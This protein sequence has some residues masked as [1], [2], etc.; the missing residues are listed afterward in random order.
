M[1]ILKLE[2]KID[3]VKKYGITTMAKVL[4]E[5]KVLHDYTDYDIKL[6][7]QEY[8]QNL[9]K[10]QYETELERWYYLKTGHNLDL[11]NPKRFT[12]KI[13]WMKLY[14]FGDLETRLVDKYLVR[15]WIKE[16]IGENYL[17]PLIGV[18]ENADEIDFSSLPKS[19]MLKGN[20][21]SQMN[22]RV[23]DK[24]KLNYKK[25]KAT[26]GQWLNLD[27]SHCLG[28]FELQYKNVPRRLLA[29]KL[30]I[31]DGKSDLSDYKFHC[32]DGK[33]KFCE[34][35][36]NR[37]TCETIDYY[38]MDWNHQNFIDEPQD[39]KIKN[40]LELIEKPIAFEEMMR[41]AEILSAEFPYVRVDLYYI[42]GHIYFGEM[43]FTPASGGDIFTPDTADYMLGEMFD[44]TRV[45]R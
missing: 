11:N 25:I 1:N 22:I 21:G 16:K 10:S 34:V 45:K 41:I 24:N 13:Q 4:Y 38:D 3:E 14:G 19:F 42:N 12:E 39:S 37:S 35:I 27:F 15:D 6:R 36:S 28:S 32:F 8:F 33:A 20:H 2:K 9:D 29:E 44:I 40:S 5:H 31:E 43:T 30:M 7:R 26:L 23:D 18:W 17:I